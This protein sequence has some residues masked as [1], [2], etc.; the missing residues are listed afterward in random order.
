MTRRTNAREVV[1]ILTERA[2][3]AIKY[4]GDTAAINCHLDEEEAWTRFC[5]QEGIPL[6]PQDRK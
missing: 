4:K 2:R 3:L 1:E 5:A 6:T